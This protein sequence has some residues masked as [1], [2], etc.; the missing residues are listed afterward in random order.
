MVR[1][2][3]SF[4]SIQPSNS[5]RCSLIFNQPNGTT[6]IA[7]DPTSRILGVTPVSTVALNMTLAR[8]CVCPV[9]VTRGADQ[10]RPTAQAH[11]VLLPFGPHDPGCDCQAPAASLLFLLIHDCKRPAR[12]HHQ[13][14]GRSVL[15]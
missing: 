7:D 11:P 2:L 1:R 12:N 3:L 9:V 10:V 8:D 4:L 5:R 6:T 13:I 14:Q 15:P